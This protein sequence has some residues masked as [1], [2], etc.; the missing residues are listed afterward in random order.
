MSR[1]I[2]LFGAM[3]VG[4]TTLGKEVAQRLKYPHFDIDR[5]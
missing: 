2:I 4:D 3:G 1:G 5:C